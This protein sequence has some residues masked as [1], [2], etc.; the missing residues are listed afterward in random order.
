MRMLGLVMLL[1]LGACSEDTAGSSAGPAVS[2]GLD[3]RVV[4]RWI[5]TFK[6]GHT[7]SDNYMNLYPDGR[8]EF[9]S[10]TE[11]AHPG[12]DTQRSPV[13]TGTW[14]AE[15]GRLYHRINGVGAWRESGAYKLSGRNAMVVNPPGGMAVLWQ[16]TD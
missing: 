15:D 3:A 16:R 1:L 10:R 2:P 4:G 6:T 5:S 12:T 14:K 13:F 7:V 11:S 8:Y 9:S